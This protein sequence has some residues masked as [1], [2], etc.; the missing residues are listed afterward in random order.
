MAEGLGNARRDVGD[1]CLH[2]RMAV[3]SLCEGVSDLVG[4]FGHQVG[5]QFGRALAQVIN[6]VIDQVI[7]QV[8][9]QG[10]NQ[11]KIL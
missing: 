1:A 7:D 9:N 4:R 11:V 2:Q 10:T 8:I 5:A 6:Q 3:R